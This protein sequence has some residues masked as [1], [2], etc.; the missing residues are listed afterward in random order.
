ML[1]LPS[2]NLNCQ[3]MMVRID[4]P[5]AL[6]VDCNSSQQVNK[7]V[8]EDMYQYVYNEEWDDKCCQKGKILKINFYQLVEVSYDTFRIERF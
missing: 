8:S 1:T 2:Q 4:I 7:D 3:I 5:W 6:R